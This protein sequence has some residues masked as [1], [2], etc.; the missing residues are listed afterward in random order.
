MT[1][2]SSHRSVTVLQAGRPC[3]TT[4]PM[5]N[6]MNIVSASATQIGD[7]TA[8]SHHLSQVPEMPYWRF[9]IM[10]LWCPGVRC[11]FTICSTHT[12]HCFNAFVVNRIRFFF[13]NFLLSLAH[14]AQVLCTSVSL[15]PC[16]TNYHNTATYGYGVRAPVGACKQADSGGILMIRTGTL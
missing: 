6:G 10:S 16:D 13:N 1:Y 11:G 3:A 14:A 9:E 4:A 7:N 2:Q 12:R 8:Q 15:R 5:Q